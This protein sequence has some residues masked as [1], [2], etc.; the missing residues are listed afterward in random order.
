MI[1]V[2]L[3]SVFLVGLLGGLHCAGMC[4]GIVAALSLSETSPGLTRVAFPSPGQTTRPGLPRIA[5]SK[6]LAYNAGRIVSY[7]FAGALA[8]TL[9]SAASLAHHLLPVQQVL[10]A[11]ANLLLIGFGLYLAGWIRLALW[12]EPAGQI[13]WKHVQPAASR[14]LRAPGLSGALGAGLLWGWVP[15]GMVY[16]VL[17]AALVSASAS[18]GAALMFAFGLG[19]LPNLLLLAW[20]A[21]AA[22]RWLRA[23][24]LRTVTGVGMIAFGL[25]GLLRLDPREHLHQVIDACLAWF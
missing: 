21:R 2:T 22:T 20:G 9:G 16:G 18:H 10:F 25:A 15:C 23:R 11:V 3:V 19:T 6:W 5:P 13:L 12:L 4:G 7:G 24:A 8:G 17:A 1:D 14:A